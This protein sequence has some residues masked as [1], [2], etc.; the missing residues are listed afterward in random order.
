MKKETKPKRG[1]GRPRSGSIYW[2]K[3]GWARARITVDIDGE[4]V[5]K[6]FDLETQ[7]RQVARAKLK[8]LVASPPTGAEQLPAE[9]ARL[10]TFEETARALLKEWKAGG[11]ATWRDRE[12]RL[13][14]Y[15]FEAIGDIPPEHMRAGDVLEVLNAMRRLGKSRQTMIHVKTDI[16]S[17]LA[18]LWR[19]ERLPE[20]VCARVVVPSALPRVEARSLKERQVLSDEELV[21]YL[22][23]Q[24]P[25]EPHQEA[26]LERQ[27]MS[28]LA[29]TFGGL[30]TGDEHALDWS[31]LDTADGR[32]GWGRAPRRKTRHKG[33]KPQRLV[34]PAVTRPILRDWWERHGKPLSGAVFPVRRGERAGKHREGGSHA[35]AFRRDLRR[36][37][38]V[39]ELREHVTIRSNGRKLTRRRWEQIRELTAREEVLLEE[40]DTTLPVDFHSWRRAYN[41]ALADAGV[42]A[43]QA[44]TLAGHASMAAH[45]R[46]L[47]RAEKMITVP[48]AALPELG[49]FSASSLQKMEP[50]N[51]ES[52]VGVR[53]FEPPTAGTQRP[54]KP[55]F[56][57]DSGEARESRTLSNDEDSRRLP[58]PCRKSVLE[59]AGE[60]KAADLALTAYLAALAQH[61]E[62]AFGGG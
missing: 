46:Y 57:D 53:G 60:R 9:A 29:R 58:Q 14:M 21:R 18:E 42:N 7:D 40:T 35:H 20:N 36:A 26:A 52:V 4:A 39:D 47:Q 45:E 10:D 43:Q 15:A 37:F 13:E 11:L 56:D 31:M 25:E 22:S 12:R 54:S 41:Q 49:V 30:R 48:A 6:T 44:Q 59:I 38:G 34:I 16:S 5:Q 3:D 8:R 61:L 51:S 23:W 55:D 33:T 28:V 32:F 1:R 27:V 62:A 50:S 19:L 17:V 2:T 24:H